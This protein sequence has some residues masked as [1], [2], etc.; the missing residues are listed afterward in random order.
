MTV[1]SKIRHK[2]GACYK[3]APARAI[4]PAWLK[5]TKPAQ[6]IFLVS[7]GRYSGYSILC[8]YTNKRMAEIR[9]KLQAD[10]NTVE[11][12]ALN[13]AVSHPPGHLL[14]QVLIGVD[15]MVYSCN[16]DDTFGSAVYLWTAL[17]NNC[18]CMYLWARNEEHAIKIANERRAIAIALGLWVNNTYQQPFPK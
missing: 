8:A 15:G 6:E 18:A 9:C 12:V 14:Y 5:K 17:T 16:Q 10:S 7:E 1:A 4:S 13:K 2:A 11:T 3:Q